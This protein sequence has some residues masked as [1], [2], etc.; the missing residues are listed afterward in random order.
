[1]AI[2]KHDN[3]S[4]PPE[5][6]ML[7]Q[8]QAEQIVQLEQA[9]LKQAQIEGALERIRVAGMAMQSTNEFQQVVDLVYQQLSQL[10]IDFASTILGVLADVGDDLSYWV[11][12]GTSEE[13]YTRKVRMPFIDSP[14]HTDHLHAYRQ[15][16][17]VFEAEYSEEITRAYF[18]KVYE[19]S[20]NVPPER[21][22]FLMAANQ[23][24]QATAICKNT[25]MAMLRF[26]G[27]KFSRSEIG[28]LK[29]FAQVFEQTYIRF[30][31]I[32]KAENQARE[33]QIEVALER[34]RATSMAMQKTKDLASVTGEIFNQ[35]KE[36]GLS[37]FNSWLSIFNLEQEISYNWF[38]PLA[39][40]IEE[41]FYAEV[42][43][44]DFPLVRGIVEQWKSK[45]PF[46]SH[47]Y[48][49]EEVKG[50]IDF[51]SES[52]G[53]PYIR[54]F[55]AMNRYEQIHV[56][57]AN[58][59]FGNLGI[60]TANL[61]GKADQEIL[62]RFAIVFEQAYTR[63]LD[64]Q[65]AEQ[66]KVQ[67]EKIFSENQ[68]LLHSILPKPIAEK[69]RQGQQTVVKRFEQVSILFAD[70]VGFTVLSEKFISSRSS[71]HPQWFILQI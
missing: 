65:K 19:L 27:S 15:G 61:P 48:A 13:G 49:G 17:E 28:I 12:T 23:Y 1:M 20:D 66:Q 5:I 50:F 40:V 51:V 64:L 37:F 52:T 35:L 43:M 45:Q 18:Q 39:G 33:A 60:G 4:Y 41:P 2:P 68:R 10:G 53:L 57:D 55:Y 21:K 38:S 56:M 14:I 32:Q 47:G 67:L 30:L 9:Q 6:K 29:R 58:H 70:I 63:F 69:I 8:K 54:E 3:F 46:T 59:R 22:V 7:L 44:K 34:V 11:S 16:L 31:D 26:D 36:L 42:S 25:Y 24:V 71:G 62:R